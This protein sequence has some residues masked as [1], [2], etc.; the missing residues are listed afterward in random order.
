MR[1]NFDFS[2]LT[3]YS[4][5]TPPSDL[6]FKISVLGNWIFNNCFIGWVMILPQIRMGESN[7]PDEPMLWQADNIRRSILTHSFCSMK[8]GILKCNFFNL[9]AATPEAMADPPL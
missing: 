5:E 2:V 7:W 6:R 4:V 3:S 9:V 1:K 8:S